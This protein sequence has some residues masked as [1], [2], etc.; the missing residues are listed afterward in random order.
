MMNWLNPQV[1]PW[2]TPELYALGKLPPHATFTTYP[3]ADAARADIVGNCRWRQSLNG[4]WQFRLAPDPTTAI[5]WATE[6]CD[7]APDEVPIEVPGNW[8]LQ[9]HGQ[10]HYTNVQMPWSHEPPHVPKDNPTGIYRRTFTPPAEWRGQRVIV[11][12]GSADSVL[13]VYCNGH[14][15]GLSKDSRLPAEFDLSPLLRDGASNELTAVV[16]K[17]SDTRFIEDQDQW[18]LSG[19]PR[20]V[21]LQA[22]PAVYLADIFARPQLDESCRRAELEVLVSVGFD[23][24]PPTDPVRVEARLF[25]P[26]GRA[27][28]RVP[29]TQVVSFRRASFDHLRGKAQLRIAVP[30]SRLRLWSAETPE[31]YQLLVSLQSEAGECHTALRVGFRRVEVRQRDLLVNGKR[32]LFKGV[33]RHEHHDRFGKAV[34]RETMRQDIERMKQFN[35]NAVRCAHYPPDPHWLDLCDE[36]GLYVIDEANIESHDFHNQLCHHPRYAGAWL[37]RVMRM[38]VRD[39]N[40]PSIILWSLGNESGYGPNHDAAAGWVRGYDASRPLHY[41]GA[42]SKWQSHLT[43]ADGARVTDVICPMY[44]PLE[45]LRAWA[46]FAAR[47][48][49]LED[50]RANEAEAIAEARAFALQSPPSRFQ[51]TLGALLP[52]I[53]RPLILCEYSHAMGNSNGSL[54]DY[55]SLFKS[56]PGL[57]GGF[58]WEWLDH[59]ILKTT[60]DG[61]AYWG[62]GGDFDDRPND[63]NFVCDGLVWPDRTPHPAMWEHKHLAQPIAIEAVPSKPGHIRIRNEHDFIDLS[64]FRGSWEW[65]VDGRPAQSGQLPPLRLAPGEE[66]ILEVPGFPEETADR[67]VHLTIRFR[68]R[69]ASAWAPRGHEVAWQQCR[70]SAPSR[71]PAPKPRPGLPRKADFASAID[72]DRLILSAGE[73]EVCFDLAAGRLESFTRNGNLFLA[74]G[75]ILQLWRAAIDNDGLKLWTGQETKP[76]GRWKALG[77]PALE[78]RLDKVHHRRASDGSYAITL[79]HRVSGRD[80]FEDISHEQRFRFLSNGQLNIS[81]RLRLFAPDL[82]DLPRVGVRL[83]L[84]SGFEELRYFGRGPWENYADRKTA[85]L[86]GTYH[87][88]VSREYVPYIMPQENGHHTDTRWLELTN[89]DGSKLRVEGDPTFEFNTSHFTTEALFAAFHTTDLTPGAETFLYLDAAHRGIGSGSCGPDTLKEYQLL[90]RSYT[91]S[92]T[93]TA[94]RSS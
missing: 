5:R 70:I 83:D 72:G 16:I 40:H 42:I 64:G 10:P 87:S 54:A 24:V 57:Q 36:F 58:I 1:A 90:E 55:F 68:T 14:F 50:A 15:V 37:D 9:G 20:E 44:M 56:T 39:Q 11:H 85:A 84:P 73:H 7:D 66:T 48:P 92:Y 29:I 49:A 65:L 34:P 18:W 94:S 28:N 63:G 51:P 69:R 38:V 27:I 33:N 71:L 12:F 17:W 53:E 75:P 30:A 59:G 89:A 79:S 3:D 76:F 61:R 88:S 31:R 8:E 43:F 2:E 22:T 32:V 41:E 86:L 6:R 25:D 45:E 62:Y 4:S 67:E 35:F 60:E 47:R 74:K 26:R 78:H 23:R 52:P 80:R 93:L 77:L 82:T 21:F 46:D 81:H 19:L 91:W 13:L